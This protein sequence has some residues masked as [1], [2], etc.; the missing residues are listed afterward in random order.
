M[1][2]RLEGVG[3][4]LEGLSTPSKRVLEFEESRESSVSRSSEYRVSH[5]TKLE[6]GRKKLVGS[7][8]EKLEC[9][10]RQHR[11]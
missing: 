1:T 7:V 5:G 8:R 4:R 9:E 2:T 3:T 6:V 10:A 11:T